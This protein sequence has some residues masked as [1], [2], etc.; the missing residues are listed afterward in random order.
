MNNILLIFLFFPFFLSLYWIF[1][2]ITLSVTNKKVLNFGLIFAVIIS[3]IASCCMKNYFLITSNVIFL[4]LSIIS[5][6]YFK[7]KKQFMFTHLRYNIFLSLFI[8]LTYLFV[9]SDN[10]ILS[11]LIWI[12]SG[13]LIYIFSYFDIFK[14]NADYNVN[15]FYSIFLIGDFCL[16]LCCFI[17]IKYAVI[18][19]TYSY[20]IEFSDI[21]LLSSYILGNSDFEYIIIPICLITALFSRAFI[22]PFA[23]FFSFLL[24]ASNLLYIVI[25][26]TVTP[27]YS[28]VLFSKLNLFD[29]INVYFRAYLLFSV[30]FILISLLFEKHFK[31]IFGYL[32]SVINSIFIICYFY[33]EFYSLIFLYCSYFI[34]TL[35]ISILFLKDKLSMK[36]RLLSFNKGFLQE[37]MHIYLTETLPLCIANTINFVIKIIFENLFKI[38]HYFADLISFY[39]MKFIQKKSV[40]VIIRGILIIFGFF[41][42]LAILIALFGNFGEMQS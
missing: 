39:Y 6:L 37:R 42:I 3:L 38:I 26:S 7:Y 16:L 25:F 13:I 33:N 32:L 4:I 1:Q 11:T 8:S 29:S 14:T 20:L 21:Q 2:R 24:N 10:L 27:L 35:S 5:S 22:F 40:S 19:T 23:C 41:A 18:S 34:L 12:I 15:R 17:F 28:L 9:L 30:I 36:K 31:I